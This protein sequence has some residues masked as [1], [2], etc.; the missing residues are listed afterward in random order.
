MQSVSPKQTKMRKDLSKPVPIPT[1]EKANKLVQQG[2]W[3]NLDSLAAGSNEYAGSSLLSYLKDN[4]SA[5]YIPMIAS[6]TSNPTYMA[7]TRRSGGEAYDYQQVLQE[8]E[9]PSIDAFRIIAEKINAPRA[10]A[11]TMTQVQNKVGRWSELR[12]LVERYKAF[13]DAFDQAQG[14]QVK[15]REVKSLSARLNSSSKA[16]THIDEIAIDGETGQLV[17]LTTKNKDTLSRGDYYVQI[18]NHYVA[19]KVYQLL[20]AALNSDPQTAGYVEAIAQ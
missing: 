19:A 11:T 7:V 1:V 10:R 9:N 15:Q 16:V 14:K 6:V 4:P 8:L 2:K 12:D 17:S 5:R 20:V 13:K 3:K 18:G